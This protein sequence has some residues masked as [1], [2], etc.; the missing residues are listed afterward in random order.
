MGIFGMLIAVPFEKI[1]EIIIN[2][3]IKNKKTQK[4]DNFNLQK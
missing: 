4:T 1:V 3:Y 2:S